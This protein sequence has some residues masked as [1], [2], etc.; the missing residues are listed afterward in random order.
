MCLA[1]GTFAAP[2]GEKPAGNVKIIADV[3]DNATTSCLFHK[4]NP[5]RIR[6]LEVSARL[7]PA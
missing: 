5:C 4:V 1:T 7:S 3:S 2:T 6:E